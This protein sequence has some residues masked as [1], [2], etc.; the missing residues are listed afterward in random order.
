MR[1]K[2]GGDDEDAEVDVKTMRLL[3]QDAA[4]ITFTTSNSAELAELAARG[5]RF[6]W[7][8]IEE[9]GKAHGF[10]MAAALQESHRLLLIGDHFQLPPFNAERFTQ[11][12]G[13]PLRVRLSIQAAASFAPGLIDSSVVEDADDQDPLDIRCA[14]WRRMVMLFGTIFERSLGEDPDQAPAATLT[15]QHRM[16][17]DIAQI[18]GKIF[19]PDNQAPSGTLLHSPD[20]THKK[21]EGDA[22]Y[23]HAENSWMPLE[24]V[25][26][27]DVEWKQK[28]EFAEG[29]VEGLFVS[30]PEVATVISVLDQL[31]P[32]DGIAC[33]L[34]IL[35]P[36]N[37][38]LG[39]IRSG[40][41]AARRAGRLSHMFGPTF[42]LG[43]NKRIGAT[44]DEF[45]GSEA[46]IVIV[47]LVRNNALVPWKSVGFLKEATRMNVLLSRARHKLIIVGSW[48]FFSSR[49]DAHTSPDDAHSY[50]GRMMTILEQ[51]RRGGRV[52]RI[53]EKGRV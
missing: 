39:A 25:V 27:C 48:D 12:L 1:K 29:E 22:P 21:F 38:Q 3:V 43:M 41:E 45:Q 5:R 37:D 17:P 31:C 30:R 47:S 52:A 16:H 42:D 8:I 19:Y 35:S 32:R 24:R 28:K 2:K 23:T 20:E 11:L 18:V 26:W 34:Q 13:E 10:D 33:E 9:A 46:D 51:G 7:S 6:D 53:S 50:L 40:I 15:D 44:V 36:Y 14:L 4:N 49:C